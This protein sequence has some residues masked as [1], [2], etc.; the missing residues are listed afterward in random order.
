MRPFRTL[1]T[2]AAIVAALGLTFASLSTSAV[3]ASVSARVP[4]THPTPITAASTVFTGRFP[5]FLSLILRGFGPRG[6]AH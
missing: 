4:P 1:F 2:A 5:H 6:A 3:R